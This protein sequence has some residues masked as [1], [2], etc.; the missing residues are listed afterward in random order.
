MTNRSEEAATSE[1]SATVASDGAPEL[2]AVMHLMW[3]RLEA[4]DKE[5]RSL[6]WI[7]AF[8]LV[9]V[10]VFGAISVTRAG[11]GQTP[12]DMLL[13]DGAGRVRARL[14]VDPR[15]SATTLELLDESGRP[16]AVLGAGAAG[17]A[18]T[19]YDR[20][21]SAKMQFGIVSESPIL[22]IT[23]GKSGR[24]RRIDLA[25]PPPLVVT[26]EPQQPTRPARTV[27]SRD[28]NPVPRFTTSRGRGCPAG[29]LGCLG[30]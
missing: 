9:T 1:P 28:P 7:M 29:T 18:L 21:G 20:S 24:T 16:Q 27:A 10:L 11:R 22:E 8:G 13:T 15:N 23:D 14:G 19:F 26:S 2:E 30:G 3:D 4:L 12:R 25:G 6:R 17:P 5:K